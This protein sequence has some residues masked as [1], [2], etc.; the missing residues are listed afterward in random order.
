MKRFYFSSLFH[1]CSSFIVLQISSA[2]QLFDLNKSPPREIDL[3]QSHSSNESREINVNSVSD[4]GS[5][6]QHSFRPVA[7]QILS[8]R[9]GIEEAHF[10]Q[11]QTSTIASSKEKTR[12]RRNKWVKMVYLRKKQG[13]MNNSDLNYLNFRTRIN[14]TYY[15][16]HMAKIKENRKRK[17][18]EKSIKKQ[19]STL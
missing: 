12:K 6:T 13:T 9:R 8:P 11:D 18:K 14:K 10:T 4:L 2:K 16:R 15:A 17:Y 19:K 1:I 7:P 3:N 5:V